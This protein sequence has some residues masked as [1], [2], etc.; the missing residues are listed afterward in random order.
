[1]DAVPGNEHHV[2]FTMR[3]PV[4]VDFAIAPFNYPLELYSHKVAAGLGAGNAVIGKPPSACPMTL[5]HLALILEEAGLPAGAHQMITGSGSRLGPPIAGS[6]A[7]D[8]VTVTGSVE[9]GVELGRICAETMKPFHAELGG[10][11]AT[12][13]CADADLEQAATGIVMGR[14][15]RGN[16]Q[17]CCS[18]KRVFVD[19]RVATEFTSIMA[20]QAGELRVEYQLSEESDV[21]PL[22]TESAA[23][24]VAARIDEAVAA[25][26]ALVSGG[27]RNGSYVAPTVL[28]NVPPDV[29]LFR[30]ETF[31]P[32]VPIVEFETIDEALAL[33][34]D[35]PYGL[36]AAVFTRDINTAMRVAYGLE[37]GGVIVNWGS[38]VRS[39]ILPFGG[40]KLTGHGRESVHDTMLSM[41]EQ[42][43]VLLFDALADGPKGGAIQ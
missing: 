33:A 13:V 43:V 28:R 16:G 11:D 2:A 4:G 41:T 22:I 32:V 25:G 36:Q 38:A 19:R 15:A 26:A 14:L 35:S 3:Q 6:P 7:V 21:G 18:V 17:I 9:T 42:K 5:L 23:V 1:M 27:T 10:N 30:L 12:I 8:M 40:L 39:E 20:R 34:N 37:A 31:G 24:A 29:P